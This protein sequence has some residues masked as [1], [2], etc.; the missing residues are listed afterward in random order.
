MSVLHQMVSR[1]GYLHQKVSN[2]VNQSFFAI[3]QNVVD[4]FA[5]EFCYHL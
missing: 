1:E 2:Y 5:P 3:Y 4:A